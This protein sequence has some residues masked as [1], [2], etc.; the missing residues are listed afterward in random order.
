MGTTT[1]ILG[2]AV[3]TV[4]VLAT[5]AAWQAFRKRLRI[6]ERMGRLDLFVELE[7]ADED[8]GAA[9]P[10]RDESDGE[11]AVVALLER[12]YPLAGGVRAG[13]AFLASAMAAGVT[14]AAALGFFGLSVWF[15]LAGGIGLGALVAWNVGAFLEGGLRVRYADRLLVAVD[16]FQ[17]MVR[18][19][20]S[21]AEAFNAMAAGAEEPVSDSLRRVRD[22]AGL[23][24]PLAAALD[25]EAQRVRVS[26][27]A[28][29]AAIVA[30]QARVGGGLAESVGNLGDML[31]ERKDNRTRLKAATAE[32]KL[33]LIVLSAVPFAAVG[34]QGAVKPEIFDVLLGDAR[35]LLGIGTGLIVVGLATAWLL[36]RRTQQ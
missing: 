29:L 18:F 15:A 32:S 30:T 14:G 26:E 2:V 13:L 19:G 16:E 8:G 25:R 36:V 27:L 6:R 7:D 35:H 3:C 1:T 9:S 28:M 5:L 11:H 21:L 17:R 34:I 23:G 24:V 33:S 4:A 12:I 22:S 10:V 20:M 31:R